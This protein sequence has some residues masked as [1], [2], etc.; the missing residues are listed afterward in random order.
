M[1]VMKRWAS[2]RT[3]TLVSCERHTRMSKARSALMPYAAMIM[4]L[5]CSIS[6]R[7]SVTL[8]TAAEMSD[9]MVSVKST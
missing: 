1:A 4:P 9:C 3:L 8:D 5:A 6:A 2:S 7:A